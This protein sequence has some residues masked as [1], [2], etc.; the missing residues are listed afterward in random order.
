[1]SN[2][3]EFI[4]HRRPSSQSKTSK[5]LLAR[6]CAPRNRWLLCILPVQKD[7]YCSIADY[8]GAEGSSTATDRTATLFV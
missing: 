5:R 4:Q 1:M 8:R 3:C 6:N 2:S 7:P